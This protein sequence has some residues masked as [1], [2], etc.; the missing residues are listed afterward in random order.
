MLVEQAIRNRMIELAESVDAAP[1]ETEMAAVLARADRNR[2][3]HL[4]TGVAAGML[5]IAVSVVLWNEAPFVGDDRPLPPVKQNHLPDER[6]GDERSHE[7]KVRDSRS[8][9]EHGQSLVVGAPAL[10]SSAG[11]K[12]GVGSSATRS[13]A[14]AGSGGYESEPFFQS[15]ALRRSHQ[16]RY[17]YEMQVVSTQYPVDG[18]AGCEPLLGDCQWVTVSSDDEYARVQVNDSSNR[19]VPVRIVQWTQGGTRTGVPLTYCGGLSP[20]FKIQPFVDRLEVSIERDGCTGHEVSPT[21]GTIQATFY[22][23]RF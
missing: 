13:D 7:T 16:Y 17:E 6:S 8:G 22:M 20:L 15:Q 21:R 5:A 2:K 9:T 19:F 10:G 11:G 4:V 14:A 18:R 23:R 3:R 12:D 1:L